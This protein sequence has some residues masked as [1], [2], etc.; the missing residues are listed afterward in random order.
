MD[1]LQLRVTRLPV[2]LAADR[3]SAT[4]QLLQRLREWPGLLAQMVHGYPIYRRFAGEITFHSPDLVGLILLAGLA[5]VTTVYAQ[6]SG[7]AMV[8]LDKIP[9]SARLANAAVSY[10]RYIGA[11]L[12]PANLAIFYPYRPWPAAISRIRTSSPAPR[13]SSI[14]WR[15][16][17]S[18]CSFRRRIPRHPID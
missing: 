5:A 12:Y 13:A 3:V 2:R 4:N 16:S 15:S 9:P 14:A 6:Q 7:G 1:V 10:V 17:S 11:L 8:T 18:M